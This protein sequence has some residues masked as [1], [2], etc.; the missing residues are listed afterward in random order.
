MDAYRTGRLEAFEY[1]EGDRTANLAP[2]F[3]ALNSF[4][5]SIFHAWLAID[6][7]RRW[8]QRLGVGDELRYFEPNDGSPIESLYDLHTFGSKHAYGLD[9]ADPNRSEGISTS[10]WLTNHGIEC[11]AGACIAYSELNEVIIDIHDL[12]YQMQEKALQKRRAVE[13]SA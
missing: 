10:I 2:Y 7:H 1:V 12:W 9:I 8:L 11:A 6:H 5:T 3:R 4:E 13:N